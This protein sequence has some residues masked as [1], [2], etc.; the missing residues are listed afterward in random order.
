MDDGSP[1][2]MRRSPRSK[3]LMAACVEQDGHAVAVTLRDLSAEGALIEGDHSL[4][5]G[6][7]VVLRKNDLAVAGRVAWA[8][9]RRAGIAFDASLA[10]ETVQ[11]NLRAPKARASAP[12]TKKRPGFR[13][14]MSPAERRLAEALWGGPLPPAQP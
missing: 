2:Q 9:G 7:A 1:E 12:V 4:E 14:R 10:A 11:R 5:P 3:L 13:G 6:A 8:K